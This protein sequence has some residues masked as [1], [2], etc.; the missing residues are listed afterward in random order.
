MGGC[1]GGDVQPAKLAA[2]RAGARY[3]VH[4]TR[5]ALRVV[6]SVQC[7]TLSLRRNRDILCV[8]FQL[9]EP[10]ISPCKEHESPASSVVPDI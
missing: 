5:C 6:T 1:T 9:A 2:L 7:T 3:T 10:R 4:C 8:R